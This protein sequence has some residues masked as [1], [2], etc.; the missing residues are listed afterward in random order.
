MGIDRKAKNYWLL[1]NG[2]VICSLEMADTFV[3][4][5]VGLLGKRSYNGAMLLPHTRAVH[6]LGMRIAIDVAFL[7]R[8]MMVVDITTMQP[9]RVG[10]PRRKGR[11]VLEAE[12]GAF[13]RWQL[14]RGDLLEIRESN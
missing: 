7:N 11:Y 9:W 14:G 12:A 10:I 1:K 8:D 2:S 13:E 4:R 3:A 6:T 5:S